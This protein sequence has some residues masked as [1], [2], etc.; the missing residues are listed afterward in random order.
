MSDEQQ[1]VDKSTISR[2]LQ[3]WRG[4]S[5]QHGIEWETPR[6][7]TLHESR[8]G[9]SPSRN[10][11]LRP[12]HEQADSVTLEMTL[13]DIE[14]GGKIVAKAI[15]DSGRASSADRFAALMQEAIRIAE[16]VLFR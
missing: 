16:E 13:H 3:T 10:R 6:T 1:T 4:M 7:S 5:R 12:R 8:Q 11:D 9:R 15:Y 2:A 14:Q